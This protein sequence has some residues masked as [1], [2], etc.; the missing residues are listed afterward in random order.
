V[1]EREEDVTEHD[2]TVIVSRLNRAV[3]EGRLTRREALRRASLLGLSATALA[4]LGSATMAR[5]AAALPARQEG[6]P[7][8]GG[9]VRV[10]IPGSAATFDP[11][12]AIILEAIWPC[13]HLYSSLVRI[14]SDMEIEPDLAL[15]WESND[16]A[17]EWTF[18]LREGVRWHDGEDFSSEDV[19]ATFERILDPELASAFRAN[20]LMIEEMQ[21]PSPT[22]IVFR[23]SVPYAE[24]PELMSNYQARIT[25]AGRSDNL[26]TD[27]IGTGPYVLAEYVPGERT[28]LRR[29]DNYFDLEGQGFLDEIQYLAIPEEATKAAALTSGGIELA[30]EFLPTTLPVIEGAPGITTVEIVTGNHQPIVMDV[31]QAPF[32]DV[33]VRTALKLCADR[34]GFLAVVLQGH[35]ETAADQPI[36]SVDPMYGDIPIPAQDLARAQELLA[37]AGYADGLDLT[38]HTSTGRPGM[39]ESALAFADMASAVGVRIELVSH[40]IDNFWA[41]IWKK[42][43]FFTTNWTGRPT[44][45]QMMSLIYL[46]DS[47]GTESKWCNE[48]FDALMA[49]ARGALDADERRN[50]LTQAQQIL[51]DDGPVVIPYFR[52]YITAYTS[53][54]NGFQAHPLRMLDLRRAWLQE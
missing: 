18:Q 4:G 41:D 19:V 32:D 52:S 22:E 50:I 34:D 51:A 54:L 8:R 25:P 14:N 6:E 39:Q 30:N 17:D 44:A 1:R 31:S 28:V 3:L 29:F 10:G 46:C 9:T 21:T 12:V 36:P 38:L 7:M 53:R 15:S 45:E 37:E 16:A 42:T 48:D 43:P 49:E 23:L 47:P 20:I 40:P 35:G 5:S 2:E 13:E 11:N 24:F 33:R 26:E 27:P